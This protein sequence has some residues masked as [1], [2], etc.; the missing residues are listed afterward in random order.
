MRSARPAIWARWRSD[1]GGTGHA[2]VWLAEATLVIYWG[3]TGAS[4]VLR[5]VND[6]TADVADELLTRLGWGAYPTVGAVIVAR[7]PH[8]R[9]GWLC[10]AVG[11]L[12]GPAFF[13]QDYAW[14]ALVHEQGSLPGGLAMAW[15]GLWPWYVVLG[16]LSF[17]LLLF[18][19]GHLASPRWRPVAWVAAAATACLGLSAAFRPRPLSG[20][21]L[22]GLTNP[23]SIQDAEA[24]FKVLEAAV[25]VIGLVTIL[26]V[27]SMVGR[28]RRAHGDERQQLKWFAA[29]AALSVLVWVAFIAPQFADRAPVAVRIVIVAIWLMAIPV[30]IGV[31]MLRYR[32]Y[33]IDR[34]IN[35]TVVYALLTALLGTIYAGVVLVFGQLFGGAAGNPPSWAVAGATLA[36]AALFQPARQ[37]IQQAVDRRFNRRRYDLAETIEAFSTRLRDEVDLDTLS[38]ELLAVV[39]QTMQPSKLSMWLRPPIERSRTAHH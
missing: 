2:G 13:A 9:I 22:E 36:V 14:Y 31:A 23:L 29:A 16:L 18:P 19:S 25:L 39:E 8:N 11:L 5:A 33:D 21:G 12:L 24:I 4:L 3:L 38:T 30:A 27:A 26:A 15:V 35:R 6:P 32:L 10:C 28:F 34:L 1:A 7:R 17:V 20:K 37:R